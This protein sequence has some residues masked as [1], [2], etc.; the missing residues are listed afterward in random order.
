MAF[1]E[2]N[3]DTW[4]PRLLSTL[5]VGVP[6]LK[7][8]RNWVQQLDLETDRFQ[9]LFLCGG[10]EL[11]SCICRAPDEVRLRILDIRTLGQPGSE[12]NCESVEIHR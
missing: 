7:D 1:T 8:Y 5:K 2:G 10:L 3:S 4:L 11:A 6:H 12:I 9:Y